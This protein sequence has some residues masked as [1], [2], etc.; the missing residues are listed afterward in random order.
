[1]IQVICDFC[2]AYMHKEF[3]HHVEIKPWFAATSV[4]EVYHR[5]FDCCK[6]CARAIEH[7]LIMIECNDLWKGKD[8]N[9]RYKNW[10]TRSENENQMQR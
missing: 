4:G 6:D 3:V 1:M 5:E 2:G 7:R 8:K 9:K 10:T